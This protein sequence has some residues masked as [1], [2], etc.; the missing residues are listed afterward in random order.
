MTTL[1]RINQENK[2]NELVKGVVDEFSTPESRTGLAA[3]L[4][5]TALLARTRMPFGMI[6]FIALTAGAVAEEAH[7][8]YLGGEKPAREDDE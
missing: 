6:L 8:R 2:L 7:A 3:T 5:T 1:A 4:A